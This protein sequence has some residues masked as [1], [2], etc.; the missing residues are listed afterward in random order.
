MNL[1]DRILFQISAFALTH[2]LCCHRMPT[3]ISGIKTHWGHW[4]VVVKFT[5]INDC[6]LATQFIASLF[7]STSMHKDVSGKTFE[8]LR[9]ASCETLPPLLLFEDHT[10]GWNSTSPDWTFPSVDNCNLA[11]RIFIA[12]ARMHSQ[13]RNILNVRV[14]SRKRYPLRLAFPSEFHSGPYSPLQSISYT[15]ECNRVCRHR[16]LSIRAIPITIFKS[17]CD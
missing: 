12:S 8:A 10:K 4:P 7:M 3:H 11:G 1:W 2:V 16:A 17:T 6:P 15:L 13:H 14:P 9:A 5:S